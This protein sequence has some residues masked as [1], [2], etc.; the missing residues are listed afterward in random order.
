MDY[1]VDMERKRRVVLTYTSYRRKS[2][3][4]GLERLRYEG[5]KR[6]KLW[7]QDCNKES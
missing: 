3:K 4:Q 6:S 2:R 1:A 5:M 7:R